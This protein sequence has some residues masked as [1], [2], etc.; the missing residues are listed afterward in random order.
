MGSLQ[1]FI[2]FCWV[3]LWLLIVSIDKQMY[4][5]ILECILPILDFVVYDFGTYI[6]VYYSFCYSE[7]LPSTLLQVNSTFW[8]YIH[9]YSVLNEGF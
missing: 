1:I 3:S 6:K 4:S 7:I 9:H 2:T 8:F 5:R